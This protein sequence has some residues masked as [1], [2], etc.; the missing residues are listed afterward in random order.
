MH[1]PGHTAACHGQFT[2]PWQTLLLAGL[3]IG[4]YF[5][6]G[7]IPETLVYNRT[8]IQQGEWWRMLTCH[9]VHS[10]SQHALWNIIA[11]LL[12]SGFYEQRYRRELL[13]LIIGSSLFISTGI[14]LFLPGLEYYCGLS[15]ILHSLLL[16]SFFRHWQQYRQP[17]F[18][19]VIALALLK[20]PVEIILN[21]AIFTDTA[22]PSLP[23]S[24]LYGVLFAFIYLSCLYMGTLQLRKFNAQ[25]DSKSGYIF[26]TTILTHRT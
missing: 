24:H 3:A 25:H 2:L 5:L 13:P 26:R 16:V 20:I 8:A 14:H 7:F 9:W 4:L 11:L 1:N 6:L 22:W 17:V 21:T 18:L 15:G 19:L 10:D 23:E 12:L